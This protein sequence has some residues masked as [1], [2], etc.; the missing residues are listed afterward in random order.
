IVS[1]T[2]YVSQKVNGC[3]SP[4]AQIIVTAQPG[5]VPAPTATTQNI[6]GSGTVADLVAQTAPGGVAVWYSSSTSTTPLQ[7]NAILSSGT[8][9]LAQQIGNCL[10][11]KVP[12]AVRIVNTSIPAV[13][14][15]ILCAGATVADLD[16]PAPTGAIHKWYINSTSTTPLDPTTVLTSG[17]Y[18]VIREQSGCESARVQ[19]QV[20]INSRPNS[21]TGAIQ[22]NF[23][24]YA[25]IDNL[26]MDQPN[27]VWYL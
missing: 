19:V 27:V 6:C 14:P 4:R 11:T 5:T 12:V 20:T 22:Q 23:V 25:E 9:Y 3:E 2:Y 10:S 16:L 13:S 1:G 24:D 15:I 18:F 7:P 17:Y 21:P 8:Y 26:V